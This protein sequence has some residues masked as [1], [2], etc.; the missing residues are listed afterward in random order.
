[1]DEVE[2]IQVIRTS[3]LRRGSGQSEDSPIRVIVQYWEMD[4]TLLC[5]I[6][7]IDDIER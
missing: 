6:D 4:G 3:L 7:P 1:M 5:E 2:V